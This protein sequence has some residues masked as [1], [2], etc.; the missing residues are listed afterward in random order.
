ME[1]GYWLLSSQIVYGAQLVLPGQLGLL[2]TSHHSTPSPQQFPEELLLAKCVLVCRNGYVPPPAAVY[3]G[4]FLV[5]ERSLGCFK[6]C[7]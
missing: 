3:D 2:S 6:N 7:R 1:E 5:L 4:P